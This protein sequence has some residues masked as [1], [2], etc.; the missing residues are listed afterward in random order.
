MKRE[1]RK[2]VIRNPFGN[3]QQVTHIYDH[4]M[5]GVVV[6]VEDD[7]HIANVRDYHTRKVSSF[8][9][10]ELKV[11]EQEQR[12]FRRKNYKQEAA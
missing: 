9:F 1:Q 3:Q 7:I 2:V 5:R 12:N 8:L 11:V 6:D 4:T 10:D